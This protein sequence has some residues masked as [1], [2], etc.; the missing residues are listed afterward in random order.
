[1]RGCLAA[2][3]LTLLPTTAFAQQGVFQNRLGGPL[4]SPSVTAPALPPSM[5]AAEPEAPLALSALLSGPG[6]PLRQGL[7]WRIYEDR[8]DGVRPAIV[9]R[10]SG[11]SRASASR[12]APTSPPSPTA[13]PAPPSGS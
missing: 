2:M 4:P 12:P 3:A 10:S 6:V 7:A 11:P 5:P 13:L 9:A 1:M 8:G